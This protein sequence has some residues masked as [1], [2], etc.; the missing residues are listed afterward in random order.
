MKKL[1]L[2]TCLAF[3]CLLSACH[4]ASLSQNGAAV[5]PTRDPLPPECTTLGL[6]VG[7]GDDTYNDA[8]IS[9]EESIERAMT[10]LRIKASDLGAT[11][12]QHDPP[13]LGEGGTVTITG[14]AYACPNTIPRSL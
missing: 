12:I 7:K 5:A 11:H 3:G 2:V 4:T 14:T 8:N 1:L 13:Q 6:L 9:K 10:D